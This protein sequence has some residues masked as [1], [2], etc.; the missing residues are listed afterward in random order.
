M[1]PDQK[2]CHSTKHGQQPTVTVELVDRVAK[3]IESGIP[4]KIAIAGESV[5]MADY[6]LHLKDHP[7]LAAL[8]QTARRKFME[9]AVKKLLEEEKPAASVR[10]LLEHC[11]PDLLAQPG[12]AGPTVEPQVIV[13]LPNDVL[14]RAREYALAQRPDNERG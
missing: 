7:D 3:R 13:G 10:W 14:E 6:Q 12:D 4:L 1:G 2:R 5:T 9:F 11:H 8:H